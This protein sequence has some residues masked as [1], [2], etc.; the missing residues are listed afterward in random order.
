MTR[1][2]THDATTAFVVATPTPSAPPPIVACPSCRAGFHR[3]GPSQPAGP[4]AR[5]DDIKQPTAF[6][7]PREPAGGE[8]QRGLARKQALTDL[9]SQALERG[10]RKSTR[11]NS[12]H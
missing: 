12:S 10:D 2:S 11:L 5:F 3:G 8:R 4:Q 9:A 6:E 7:Q 1:I